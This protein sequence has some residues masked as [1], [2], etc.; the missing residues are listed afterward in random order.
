MTYKV[1]LI[2]PN[3]GKFVDVDRSPLGSFALPENIVAAAEIVLSDG[4]N[5]ASSQGSDSEE[6]RT[7]R[8][9]ALYDLIENHKLSF[10]DVFGEVIYWRTILGMDEKSLRGVAITV[11]VH[12]SAYRNNM[13]TT[14]V[15]MMNRIENLR[16]VSANPELIP[17]FKAGIWDVE[18]ASTFAADSVDASLAAD[19]MAVV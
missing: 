6:T 2:Y 8:R 16:K 12:S 19:L 9:M 11:L 7:A 4:I 15:M 1:E 17:Y 5:S 3:F 13:R 10:V 18:A 14:E